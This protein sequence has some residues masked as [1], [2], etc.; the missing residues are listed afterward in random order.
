MTRGWSPV[1]ITGR[2]GVGQATRVLLIASSTP[3]HSLKGPKSH[4][5]S[6]ASDSGEGFLVVYPIHSCLSVDTEHRFSEG[7]KGK[8]VIIATLRICKCPLLTGRN[9]SQQPSY[10]DEGTRVPP[11]GPPLPVA[12][13]DRR[14]PEW[15]Q[16][17]GH[18]ASLSH[19]PVAPH[20]SRSGLVLK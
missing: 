8:G 11:P 20:W 15:A 3:P 4:Q 14:L 12:E 2:G 6:L 19:S 17:W 18:V 9:A 5:Q 7:Q 10:A 16:M 13:Q 1:P